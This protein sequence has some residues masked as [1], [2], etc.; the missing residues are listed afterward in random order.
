M[1]TAAVRR[2]REHEMARNGKRNLP[3]SPIH[4]SEIP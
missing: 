1:Y 2:S 4:F 3:L